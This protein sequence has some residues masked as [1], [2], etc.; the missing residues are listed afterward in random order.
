[1]LNDILPKLEK[2]KRKDNKAWACCPVHNDR[3]PS[4]M[5][6]ELDDR[7]LIHCFA[8]QANGL[9]VVNALG[10]PSTVLFRDP[11]HSVIPKKVIDK[12]MEDLY[13]ID[14]FE[15]EKKKGSR[16]TYNDLKRYK[17]AKERVKLLE[18]S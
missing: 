3:N 7:V 14:I 10:L 11:K 9:E 4:M 5:L 18:A 15:S 6:T 13:F 1:M 8:C 12:A 2:V 17:L 16:I